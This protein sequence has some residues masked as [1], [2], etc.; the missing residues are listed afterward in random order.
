[1]S[2]NK[3]ELK[4]HLHTNQRLRHAYLSM[5]GIA[6]WKPTKQAL[7]SHEYSLSENE[8]TTPFFIRH[9]AVNTQIHSAHVGDAHQESSSQ[10][11]KRLALESRVNLAEPSQKPHKKSIADSAIS[12]P[13]K[14]NLLAHLNLDAPPEN[15]KPL[16]D[17]LSSE[18]KNKGTFLES[19]ADSQTEEAKSTDTR[20]SYHAQLQ[21]RPQFQI[22]L[23]VLK[24]AC[25]VLLDCPLDKSYEWSSVQETLLLNILSATFDRQYECLS[26]NI[27]PWPIIQSP[28]IDQSK[29]VAQQA[30]SFKL[31]HLCNV[32]E[33]ETVLCFGKNST[34]YSAG[35][36]S[37]V[38]KME[39]MKVLQFSH[40]LDDMLLSPGLK[41]EV[42]KEILQW[43]AQSTT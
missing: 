25:I 11:N 8:N 28:E 34:L 21:A 32:K 24:P 36:E 37:Q 31:A 19:L 9:A 15:D 39:K 23:C 29:M 18:H 13:T 2:T 43:Q 40:S 1:M 33:V 5:M 4:A 3:L 26:V 14:E 10:T 20:L 30:I 17:K 22:A 6:R 12:R 42:W 38:K 41:R 35:F 7:I 16:S 27:Y